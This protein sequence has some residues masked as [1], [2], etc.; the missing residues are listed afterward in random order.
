MSP[1]HSN[2]MTLA[3]KKKF[4]LK[5]LMLAVGSIVRSKYVA[6][7][8]FLIQVLYIRHSYRWLGQTKTRVEKD[9]GPLQSSSTSIY[10]GWNP[11]TPVCSLSSNDTAPVP[12]I[13]LSR[14]RSGS[15]STWQ[16]MSNLTGFVTRAIEWPGSSTAQSAAFFNRKKF[17]DY[18]WDNGNWILAFMC[19]VQEAFPEAGI[20]GFKWKPYIHH[21]YYQE[22]INSMKFL[23]HSQQIKVVR[24]RRNL[25]DVT[26]SRYKH[27]QFLGDAHCSKDD[28]D[29]ISQHLDRKVLIPAK[30]LLEVLQ[31]SAD[32]E[33]EVDRLLSELSVPHIQVTYEKLYHTNDT[34]EWTRIFKFLN[35]G[36]TDELTFVTLQNVQEHAATHSRLHSATLQNYEEVRQE[37]TGT[38]FE[39]LLH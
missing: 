34:K 17:K 2:L 8:L 14:G 30:D 16:I 38:A 19:A 35:R 36:P 24:L 9:D 25:L 12:V 29:C 27:K 32:E 1:Y 10:E 18:Q 15:A 4:T 5:Q 28:I 23:A 31:K 7:I 13:L 33:D 22:F 21:S 11:S 39:H 26:I 37:L 3:K 6:V 20:V